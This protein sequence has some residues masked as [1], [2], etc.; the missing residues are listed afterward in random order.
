MKKKIIAMMCG[1][2]VV[3]LFVFIMN[4]DK[5]HSPD[6]VLD[7]ALTKLSK[8]DA[9][10]FSRSVIDERF[11]DSNE[12]VLFYKQDMEENPVANYMIIKSEM[13]D[14]DHYAFTTIKNFESEYTVKEPMDVKMIEGEWK[15]YISK[16]PLN[17]HEYEVVQHGK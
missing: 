10:G 11:K 12:A 1:V 6:E 16:K 5:N 3:G 17:E 14:K 7:D 9:Y 2:L 8:Q 15:V 4:N 13:I